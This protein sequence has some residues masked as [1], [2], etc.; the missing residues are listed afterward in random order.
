[1]LAESWNHN[2]NINLIEDICYYIYMSNKYLQTEEI[3]K[4][5]GDIQ[6]QLKNIE[7]LLGGDELNI[8]E[9]LKNEKTPPHKK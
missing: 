7:E 1:M 9:L 4:Q 8:E 5:I 3:R 2:K 6:N